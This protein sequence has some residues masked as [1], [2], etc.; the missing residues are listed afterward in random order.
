[1]SAI[2]EHGPEAGS[3]PAASVKA[4][5]EEPAVSARN[6]RKT[7]GRHI[8]VEN[9]S[10]SVRKGETFGLL[11]PNGA[12]K[13]TTI[14]CLQGLRAADA[15]TLRVLGLDPRTHARDLRGRV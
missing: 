3:L 15:G 9:V 1:M 8:A 14:E 10:F 2:R 11:G 5:Q 7:Y 12:G 6:L 4:V 13:T